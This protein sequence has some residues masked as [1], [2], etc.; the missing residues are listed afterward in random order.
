MNINKIRS[1]RQFIKGSAGIAAVPFLPHIVNAS[2]S[3]GNNHPGNNDSPEVTRI[4]AEYVVN[5][6]F[7]EIP[8][9]AIN[10]AV[11]SVF[12]IVGCS[13]GGSLH[14]GMISAL[15]A[16][17]K[18]ASGGQ[19]SVLGRKEKFPLQ[20]A[21]LLNGI[22]S[23]VLDFDDTHLETIIHPAGPVASALFPLSEYIGISGKDFLLAF[24]LGVEVECRIGLSVYPAH[25]QAGWHITGTAGVFGAAAAVGKL[26]GLNTEQMI[27]ALGIAATQSSGFK[28]MFGT[29]CKSFHPGNAARSG[30]LAAFLAKENFTST[31]KGI[32]ADRSFAYVMS[33][34]RDFSFITNGLGDT[35]EVEKN[36]YK[37]FACG[38]VIHPV[39]DGCIQLRSEHQLSGDHISGVEVEVHPLVLELTGKQFPKTG[40]EGKFSVYHSCSVAILYG[41]ASPDQY[42]DE[43]VRKREVISLRDK[44]RA[45]SD[46]SLKEDQAEVTVRLTDGRIL[47]KR[48]DHAIGSLERPMTNEQLCSKFRSLSKGIL[49][50]KQIDQLIDVSFDFKNL[51]QVSELVRLTQPGKL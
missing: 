3:S 6:K 5:A 11:R 33:T 30:M 27:W 41:E 32:E 49:P 12:N 8:P 37:P 23:H 2:E 50:A 22:S 17:G 42:T 36:T 34:D 20:E 45:K 47:R 7:E 28:E 25:Y 31:T 16:I 13:I 38:I 26:L 14:P 51:K 44:V 19:T 24:I 1:R 4:L 15:S 10:E 43:V 46:K 9:A 21:A 48:I 18:L 40:L 35:F 29:M 39:I